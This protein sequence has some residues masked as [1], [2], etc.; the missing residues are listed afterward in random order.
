MLKVFVHAARPGSLLLTVI[1]IALGAG[2]AFSQLASSTGI[3]GHNWLVL[4][5]TLWVA[6][7][8]HVLTN[9]ANG[10]GDG[11]KGTDAQREDVSADRMLARGEM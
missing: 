6:M 1:S 7:A 10:Y 11:L 8:L 9:I 3:S 2:L 4:L 5:L